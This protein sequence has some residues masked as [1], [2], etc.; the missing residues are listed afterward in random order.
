MAVK[1]IGIA[2]DGLGVFG[3]TNVVLNWASILARS[4]YH[5]DIIL[6]PSAGRPSIPFLS[7]DDARR[8]HL[9][10][11]PE[12]RRHR[13]HTVIATWWGSIAVIAGLNADHYVWFMQAYEGQFLP[14]NSPVQA[15]FD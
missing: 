4:G 6:P 15:D 11:E 1:R 3:G 12:A 13:Y 10:A 7:D 5:L 14:L 2:M 8:L 9:I